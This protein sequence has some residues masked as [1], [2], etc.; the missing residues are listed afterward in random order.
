MAVSR[1]VQPSFTRDE[2]EN[3]HTVARRL[4]RRMR[5]LASLATM[6]TLDERA[7][8][9]TKEAM[10][11]LDLQA[12][13]FQSINDVKKLET[14]SLSLTEGTSEDELSRIALRAASEV[15]NTSGVVRISNLITHYPSE[16][17]PNDNP[18]VTYLGLPLFDAQD[19]LT[20]V[21]SIFG[22]AFREFNEEDQWWLQTA[23]QPVADALAYES[24]TAKLLELQHVLNKSSEETI[25]KLEEKVN[26]DKLSILVIDDD[27]MI[28]ELICEFLTDEGYKAEAAYDGLEAMRMFRPSEHDVILSDVAMPHMNGWELIAALRVR[29]PELPVILITGYGSGNWNETYLKKQGVVAVLGKP[30]DMELLQNHLQTIGAAKRQRL[31]GKA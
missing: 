3:A 17:L 26:K 25:G 14:L 24:V 18:F 9:L 23:A 31:V 21:A 2:V 19:N 11:V 16:R 4:R 29:A 5:A 7:S 22:S 8:C 30:I 27:Q 15:I 28:N 10:T 12:C 1:F 6:R 20:A 13:S